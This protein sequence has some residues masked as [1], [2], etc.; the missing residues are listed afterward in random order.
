MGRSK[1]RSRS[2]NLEAAR[3]LYSQTITRARM[4]TSATHSI[5]NAHGI[6]VSLREPMKCP[7]IVYTDLNGLLCKATGGANLQ[8]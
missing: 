3:A 5:H 2:L 6:R 1:G 4:Q 8:S 7:R